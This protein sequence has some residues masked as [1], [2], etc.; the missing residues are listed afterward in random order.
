MF[1]S[2]PFSIFGKALRFS[3]EISS[4]YCHLS[5]QIRSAACLHM[6]NVFSRAH[7]DCMKHMGKCYLATRNPYVFSKEINL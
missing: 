5:L 2:F 6:Q 3:S 4:M 1:F 7:F